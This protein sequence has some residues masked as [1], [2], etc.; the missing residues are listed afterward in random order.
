MRQ[1][2]RLGDPYSGDMVFDTV[3]LDL[4]QPCVNPSLPALRSP[5]NGIVDGTIGLNALQRRT[6]NLALNTQLPV[7][8]FL[9]SRVEI[10]MV[11]LSL[12]ADLMVKSKGRTKQVRLI[13][14]DD[15]LG[16]PRGMN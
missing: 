8:S 15:D 1:K 13:P 12:K 3:V 16:V 9:A 14:R 11:A 7:S 2:K 10:T 4:S 6:A 5:H